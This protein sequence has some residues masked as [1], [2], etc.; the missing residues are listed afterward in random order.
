[1][2]HYGIILPAF[3]GGGTGLEI[4]V[5]GGADA[6]VLALYLMG[7]NA[8]TMIGLY[9]APIA[10]IQAEIHSLSTD[11]LA[12][13]FGVLARAEFARYDEPTQMVWVL[14]MARIRL[15]L[16]PN[17]AIKENDK[18]RAAVQ[19]LYDRC[20]P[21]PFL[22]P[23]HQKYSKTL[24]MGERR[25]YQGGWKPL[26]R[27]FGGPT[28]PEQIQEQD[29]I[30]KAGSGKSDQEDQD[31]GASRVVDILAHLQSAGHNYIESNPDATD[32]DLVEELKTVAA[33]CRVPY[34][35]RQI[36]DVVTMV[37]ATRAR[38]VAA[39]QRVTA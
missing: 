10:I 3:W 9:P 6:Q 34:D 29:Q 38:R 27:S 20:R 15:G 31:P 11:A 14:E 36:G 35:G 26:L 12:A 21:N 32:P 37:R 28:K 7:N 25:R 39:S 16:S 1:M 23:F 5:N 8:A 4:A 18:R 2:S 19:K 24:L 22:G 17:E 33:R 13:A 30:Q